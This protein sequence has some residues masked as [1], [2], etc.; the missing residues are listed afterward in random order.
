[1]V[2]SLSLLYEN[3]MFRK[4][5]IA[6][7]GSPLGLCLLFIFPRAMATLCFFPSLGLTSAAL[8]ASQQVAAQA[9]ASGMFPAQ[10]R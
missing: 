5:Q 2:C 8:V 10:R 6:A 9:S 1:M 3:F 7:A 4:G